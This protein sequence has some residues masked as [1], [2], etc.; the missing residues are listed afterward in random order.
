VVPAEGFNVVLKVMTSFGPFVLDRE[1]EGGI[2]R[3]DLEEMIADYEV[4][5]DDALLEF[6][7]ADGATNL[8]V[9]G[10]D[11]WTGEFEVSAVRPG[12]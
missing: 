1:V 2:E 5:T 4:G 10:F 3:F 7:Y 11:G 6:L 12:Q 8:T 9:S